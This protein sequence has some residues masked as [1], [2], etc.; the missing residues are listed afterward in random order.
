MYLSLVLVSRRCQQLTFHAFLPHTPIKLIIPKQIHSFGF[1]LYKRPQLATLIHH[2][3]ITPYKEDL[4]LPCVEIV[5]KCLNLK[6]LASNAY[7]VRESITLRGPRHRLSHLDCKDLTL[8]WT[9]TEIWASLLGTPNG[10]AL[11]RQLTHLRLI[12]DR[13]PTDIPLPSLTHLSYGSDTDINVNIGM[14]MMENLVSC[15][16]LK[17]VIVTK[18]GASGGLRIS[19]GSH[20]RFFTFELASKKT[21]SE[22]ELWSDNVSRRGMW[23]LCAD[24]FLSE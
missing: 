6:S 15:P 14:A 23:A 7:M 4:L 19:R 20:S 22:M 10:L 8:L 1:L 3:W 11:F 21:D 5:K 13:F 2:L 9:S 18:V 24:P 16:S 17:T 12:G